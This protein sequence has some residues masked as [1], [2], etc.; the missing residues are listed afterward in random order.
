MARF[1]W[2]LPFVEAVQTRDVDSL[3][4]LLEAES[5]T[6]AGTPKAA[7][8]RHA[9]KLTRRY[10]GKEAYPLGL[11]L[12]RAD[13]PT[14]KELGAILLAEQYATN[15]DEVAQVL[16]DLADDP[17]WEVREWVA[18][19]CGLVLHGH[20]AS[21]YPV[22]REWTTDPSGQVRR[23]VAL[24]V[25]YAAKGLP[26]S[27]T[28][29]LLDLLEPLLEDPDPYVKK[30][31]GPFAIGDGLLRHVPLLVLPRLDRWADSP[32]EQVRWNVAMAFT[33]AVAR[34]YR[35]EGAVILDK[36]APDQR[37]AVKRAVQAARRN[38]RDPGHQE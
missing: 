4:T 3:I 35:A 13:N 20:Y 34:Q 28:D 5:T 14:A 27:C 25:M 11:A 36:L 7:V 37:P 19:A 33:S 31:L 16:R 15:P 38:L 30:N 18:S 29:P 17:N 8:K 10:G 2:E 32:S 23:A 6:H 22:L 9:L 21:F 24:A 26:E 12:A 1:Q